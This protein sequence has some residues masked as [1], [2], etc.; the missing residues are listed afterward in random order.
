MNILQKPFINYLKVLDACRGAISEPGIA[1]RFVLARNQLS[2]AFNE[3]DREATAHRLFSLPASGRAHPEQVVVKNLT[4][5]EL[6]DLYSIHMIGDSKPARAYYDQIKLIAPLRKCPFCGFGQV[7]TLDHFLSKARY[8]TFS[9]LPSNLIPSCSDCNK[10]KGSSIVTQAKQL[11]HPY[12][13]SKCIETKPWLF[14]EVIETVPPTVLYFVVP[15]TSYPHDLAF[16]VRNHFSD[17]ELERRF[18]IEAT[19]EL[20]TLADLLADLNDYDLINDH[21]K[22]VARVER[23]HR[24]NSWKAALYDALSHNSW[25]K[26]GGFRRE[27]KERQA[28][29]HLNFLY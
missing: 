16:R 26:N 22:R 4:K 7:T 18:S 9:I 25:Y 1:L 2:K 11:L 10:G 6:V 12:F 28:T 24:K 3:Y 15:P 17:F 19:T 8:P 27:V 5:G 14:V 20:S 21:L 23:K 29:S 13:E